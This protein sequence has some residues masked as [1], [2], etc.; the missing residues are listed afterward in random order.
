MVPVRSHASVS[1]PPCAS[2][3]GGHGSLFSCTP[4]S[5]LRNCVRFRQTTSSCRKSNSTIYKHRFSMVSTKSFRKAQGFFPKFLNER[6]DRE[7][8]LLAR[9]GNEDFLMIQ[10]YERNHNESP[11]TTRFDFEG[12]ISTLTF[13]FVFESQ[14]SYLFS[15]NLI[16]RDVSPL[17]ACIERLDDTF[18]EFF[19]SCM[20]TTSDA[21]LTLLHVKA[22]S[23]VKIA[24]EDVFFRRIMKTS[25]TTSLFPFLFDWRNT[26]TLCSITVGG[27]SEFD[28]ALEIGP[29]YISHQAQAGI[30]NMTYPMSQADPTHVQQTSLPVHIIAT[31]PFFKFF[32]NLTESNFLVLSKWISTASNSKSTLESTTSTSSTQSGLILSVFPNFQ[33]KSSSDNFLPM[34]SST[35]NPLRGLGGGPRH[36]RQR[37]N[38]VWQNHHR[39]NHHHRRQNDQHQN[40]HQRRQNVE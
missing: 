34:V 26:M 10:M 4:T 37:Q 11:S 19:I 39:Q 36:N 32:Y 28:F 14:A 3:G 38:N 30:I 5:T 18:F 15:R 12:C 2:G 24:F 7:G 25:V 27:S 22:T 16:S 9:C 35:G 33:L 40:H 21:T 13:K 31:G 8:Y 20:E 29:P 1:V 23:T 6:K 17:S